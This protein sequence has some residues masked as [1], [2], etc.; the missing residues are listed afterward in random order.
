M[1]QLTFKAEQA[2]IGKR[3][4][5]F[6]A[7]RAGLTRS[8]SQKVLADGHTL[9]NGSTV[10]KNYKIA[11]N[12]V[13]EVELPE[14]TELDCI[15]EDIPVDIVYEDEHLA[16][17]NKPKGM[18]VHPAPGNYTGT[19]VNALLYHMKGR[20]S[21]INGV[22]RPGI[23]HR[24][25]KNTSGLLMI[26]K[27][28]EAHLGLAEQIKDHSFERRYEAILV[29]NLKDDEGTIDAPIGRHPEDRKKMAIVMDG[30]EAIT[31]YRVLERFSGFCH[32]ELK[33]ETGRTHQ[34]R[35]HSKSVGHPVL[36]DTLYGAGKTKF[37]LQ[38]KSI[39]EEQTL[40]AR[41]VG[42]VHPITGESLSFTSDLPE[43]FDT[44]LTKLR[45]M[46]G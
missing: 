7:E 12:D 25:D 4:D 41:T 30:R 20:L 33:L 3:I 34:I 14:P 28:D 37:E 46:E 45:K 32:V 43:Y 24:I 9:V 5:V 8:A 26:A 27:T 42:F 40:H 13:V 38:N 29:G 22:I 18:V 19:L 35:V 1:S 11:E 6:V 39:I 17:V 21:S 31:H 10:R 36:G 23:V 2:D 44:L 16:V 15:P